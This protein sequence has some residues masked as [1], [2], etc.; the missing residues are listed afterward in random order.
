MQLK[1]KEEKDVICLGIDNE[2]ELIIKETNGQIKKVLSGE[3]TFK[4]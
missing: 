3:L 4:I 2:G 1:I